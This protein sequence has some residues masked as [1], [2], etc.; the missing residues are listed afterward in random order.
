MGYPVYASLPTL[1]YV[2]LPVYLPTVH[3]WVHHC[4]SVLPGHDVH[5]AQVPDD[6]A[7]GSKKEKPMGG[8]A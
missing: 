7:L 2:H 6:G 5:H 8:E 1:G 3:P 4:M